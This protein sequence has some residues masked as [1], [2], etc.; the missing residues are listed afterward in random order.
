MPEP[1]CF[2]SPSDHYRMR[3]EFRVWHD[4]DDS[5]YIMFDP[6]SRNKIRIDHFPVGNRQINHLMDELRKAFLQDPVL[7]FKL[8]QVEFLTTTQDQALVSMIYHRKLDD[9]WLTRA[10]ELETKLN[11]HLI[12]RSRKQ[13]IVV[14][15]E[16]VEESFQVNGKNYRYR[17]YENGFTQPNA[18]VCEIMLNWAVEQSQNSIGDLL[19]LYCGNGNF[20]LP[21]STNFEKVLA[22]EISKTS[23]RSAKEN[24]GLNGIT[25]VSF[26]KISSEDF[27]QA[28]LGNDSKLN[29]KL[30]LN[31]YQFNTVFVDP[32]RAGLDDD[33]VELVRHFNR[34]LYISCNPHTLHANAKALSNS[35]R[36]EAF[37]LF[38]QFPY[39]EH[40][41][42]GMVLVRKNQ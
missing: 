32:P 24:A 14:S 19:E 8:Y 29:Q 40:M 20:T 41:E 10:K 5:F 42:C 15:E 17:Q 28:W 3:A 22:T 39:T 38:D 37:A 23:I 33:T 7:R 26:E 35:H 4:G 1:E 16:F 18:T 13:R 36:V 11:I 2:P 12:G 31:Q 21:L 27:S 25:N 30:N 34:I 6:I 9:E